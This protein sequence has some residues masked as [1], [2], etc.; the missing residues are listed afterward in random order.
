MSE[1]CE[2]CWVQ[3]TPG[4]IFGNRG[5]QEFLNSLVDHSAGVE[6]VTEVLEVVALSCG[7][8]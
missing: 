3:E 8:G 1:E 4:F 6:W 5:S 2:V 7:L